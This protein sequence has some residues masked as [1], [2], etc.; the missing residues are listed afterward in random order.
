MKS[1]GSRFLEKLFSFS[2]RYI[3]DIFM[4]HIQ[5]SVTSQTEHFQKNNLCYSSWFYT[6]LTN[7]YF[8][9]SLYSKGIFEESGFR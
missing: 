2:A 3:E 6:S 1:N 5:L 8:K 7:Q 9:Y 4:R